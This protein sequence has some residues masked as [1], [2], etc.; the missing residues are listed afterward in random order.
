MCALQ[1]RQSSTALHSCSIASRA[2]QTERVQKLQTA[3]NDCSSVLQIGRGW[4]PDVPRSAPAPLLRVLAN[5][6]QQDPTLRWSAGRAA[7]ELRQAL[8]DMAQLAACGCLPCLQRSR[9]PV[10]ADKAV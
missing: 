3:Y 1:E 8:D 9:A 5:C 4:R 2:S 7:M 6:W 10:T